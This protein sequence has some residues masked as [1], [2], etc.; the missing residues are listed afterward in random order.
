MNRHTKGI[1]LSLV[2]AAGWGTEAIFIKLAYGTNLTTWTIIFFRFLIACIIL[3][4]LTA[5]AIRSRFS[6]RH[7]LF[8][9]LTGAVLNTS[10][11]WCLT[12]SIKHIPASIA[13]TCLYLYPSIVS[14]LSRFF[15]KEELSFKKVAVLLI[16]FAGVFLISWSGD[17]SLNM[18]GVALAVSAA[19]LNAVMV[20]YIKKYLTDAN[21]IHVSSVV[22]AWS[23]IGFG[24]IGLLSSS[25]LALPTG[26]EAWLLVAGLGLFST[27]V[28]FTSLYTGLSLI[29]ASEAAIISSTEP[30]ITMVLAFVI[31]GERLTILQ[32]I[33]S[34]LVIGGVLLL[35]LPKNQVSTG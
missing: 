23:T 11:V 30:L 34:I 12:L 32:G 4:P 26:I 13:I 18:A 24:I 25:P 14:V 1:I 22:L 8:M 17:S 35:S 28:P 15:L 27:V 5:K 21:P 3:L 6:A 29:T 33:G 31:L 10:V 16:S 2:A 19:I 20:V 9:L 7:H